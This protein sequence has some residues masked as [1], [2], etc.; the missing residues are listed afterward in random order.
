[1]EGAV[2]LDVYWFW[3][4]ATGAGTA[5]PELTAITD[6]VG[7]ICYVFRGCAQ[8]GT[9]YEDPTVNEDDT[10]DITPESS[11]ITTTDVDR[12]V[13]ASLGGEPSVFFLLGFP[14]T[15]W[16][17][18][19]NVNTPTGTG[20]N[21]ALMSRAVAG[22]STVAAVNFGTYVAANRCGTLTL[23]FIGPTNFIRNFDDTVTL[24][25]TNAKATGL[26]QV[27][28]LSVSDAQ[29]KVAG[30]G[31]S[32]NVALSDALPFSTLPGSPTLNPSTFTIG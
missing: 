26:P 8:Q 4:R 21:S 30:L 22:A 27:D 17:A 25:D 20:F 14:P 12:L 1:M 31:R 9:P 6:D 24:S 2:N 10:G 32:D 28:S 11:E 5:G 18:D 23:A 3:K 13:V 16:T 7:A 29:T 19:S 15:D